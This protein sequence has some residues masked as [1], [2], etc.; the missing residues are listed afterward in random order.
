MTSWTCS[1]GWLQK[2]KPPDELDYPIVVSSPKIAQ[3]TLCSDK[4]GFRFVQYLGSAVVYG[5]APGFAQDATHL[6]M[7][8]LI[9]GFLLRNLK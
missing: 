2:H 9:L 3:L 4:T 6:R 7:E 5:A 1:S 8:G